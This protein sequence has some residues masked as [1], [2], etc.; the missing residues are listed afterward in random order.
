MNYTLNKVKTNTV[1][2]SLSLSLTSF[3]FKFSFAKERGCDDGGDAAMAKNSHS[4]G[5][6]NWHWQK[7]FAGKNLHGKNVNSFNEP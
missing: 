3:Y 4:V 5:D 7:R 6:S 1:L 2:S